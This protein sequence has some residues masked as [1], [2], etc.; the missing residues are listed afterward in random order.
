MARIVSVTGSTRLALTEGWKVALTAPGVAR[1]PEALDDLGLHFLP[2]RVPS[3]A[4]SVLRADGRWA[5]GDADDFD[6]Q[7]GWWRCRFATPP[8]SA[9]PSGRSILRFEG[10]ATIAEV[11]LNGEQLLASANMFRAAEVDIT[12]LLR[13]G[14]DNEIDIACRALG[15]RLAPPRKPR[16]RWKTRLVPDQ[17]L[18]WFRTA[19]LGRMPGMSPP[20]APVGPYRPIVLETRGALDVTEVRVR[21]SLD[22]VAGV[23]RVEVTLAPGPAL[24]TLESAE[25]AIGGDRGPL[26]VKWF[27]PEE[28]GG[29]CLH[30]ELRLRGVAPWWPHTHGAPTRYPAAVRVRMGGYEQIIDLGAVGF[31]SIAVD[32]G[33]DGEGFGLVINGAAVFARG[34]CWATCDLATLNA[35]GEALDETLARVCR[36][37]MN[38]IRVGGTMVPESDDFYERCDALGILVFQDF[39]FA[40]FDYPFADPT[41]RAEALAEAEELLGRLEARACLAVL[42]GSSE[43]EQQAAMLGLPRETWRGEF[44]DGPLL[45]LA[46]ARCPGVPYVPSTPT[47]GP[48]PFHVDRGLGHYYG[49]GAYLRPLEDARRANVRF[50]PECLAFANVPAPETVREVALDAPRMKLTHAENWKARVPRDRGAGWDFEDVRDHYLGRLFGVDPA[51]L[52]A[53]DPA[54]YLALG[55]V[56][57]GE[58]MSATYGELRRKG[59]GCRGALVWTLQDLWPGAGF[60]LLD[61]IG[62]PKAAYH[63]L[64]RALAPVSL[65]ITDEGQ[66]G[67]RL[68]AVNDGAEAIPARVSVALLRAGKLPTATGEAEIMVP[69]RGV[70]AVDVDTLLEGF[71]D[72]AYAYRFGPPDH[73]VVVAR[74]VASEG[75]SGGE[76][77]G[78][79]PGKGRGEELASA[80]HFPLGYPAARHADLGLTATARPSPTQGAGALALT[81]TTARFA[82]A[83]AIRVPGYLPDDDYLHVAPGA[84]RTVVLRPEVASEAGAPVELGAL[85]GEVSP[86]NAEEATAVR[87]EG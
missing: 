6:A 17:N 15:P 26:A 53:A 25:L 23:A 56:V 39:P 55:R 81:L 71:R 72:P 28:G 58:V 59:S 57:T 24:E 8:E 50:A 37:G 51:S 21:T 13:R 75:A 1:G 80:V 44:F 43:V 67:L 70:L 60:G 86:T 45:A 78:E 48:L 76:S 40:N 10:L 38:M 77:P 62:R 20:A 22:G 35:E 5:I 34:A 87:F 61:A 52:R 31:R 32:R 79:S 46:E 63:Y 47:S 68:H 11:W 18:R 4:A 66:N 54:R 69:A 85:S 49:V 9:D 64:A 36:A 65:F 82:Y 27:A 2:A 29:A 30:G 14:A 16:P 41:F 73:D 33:P 3:T 12:R 84:P 7:D 19:L 42:C 83:C 74:L